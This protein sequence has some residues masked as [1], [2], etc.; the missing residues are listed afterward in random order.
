M[1]AIVSLAHNPVQNHLCQPHAVCNDGVQPGRR[2]ADVISCQP[3]SGNDG[4][5]NYQY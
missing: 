1:G 5:G 3:N 2:S 4:C